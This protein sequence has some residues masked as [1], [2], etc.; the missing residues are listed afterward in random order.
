MGDPYGTATAEP[1]SSA[2]GRRAQ[3]VEETVPKKQKATLDK[4]KAASKKQ[5]AAPKKR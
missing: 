5:K 2:R 4:Q 3:A 1:G